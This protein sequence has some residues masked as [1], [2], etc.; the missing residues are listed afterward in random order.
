MNAVGRKTVE[1][2]L[3]VLIRSES[4]E[5]YLSVFI[6]VCCFCFIFLLFSVLGVSAASV[7]PEG[8]WGML[9]VF[10]AQCIAG[11]LH[12]LMYLIA[13]LTDF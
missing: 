3:A 13:C 7:L 11:L 1:H 4:K 6:Q 9:V 5:L 2:T 8:I 10:V 12:L